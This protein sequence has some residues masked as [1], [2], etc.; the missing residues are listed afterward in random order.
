M[1]KTHHGSIRLPLLLGTLL[2]A[3]VFGAWSAHYLW[4]RLHPAGPIG[5]TTAS[6]RPSVEA[7]PKPKVKAKPKLD[8][9]YLDVVRAAYPEFPATQPLGMPLELSHAAHLILDDPIYL[10]GVPRSEMWITRGD[11]PPIDVVLKEAVDP[12]KDVDVHLVRERIVFVHWTA[13]EPYLVYR[14]TDGSYEVMSIVHGRQ[15]FPVQRRFHWEH[16]FSWNK[17]VVVPAGHGV[18]VFRFDPKI[19]EEYHELA[20]S[21]STTR[22]ASEYPEPRVFQLSVDKP[23]LIAWLPWEDGKIGGTGA[24]RYAEPSDAPDPDL[25]DGTWTDL[26]PQAGWPEKILH[27]VPLRDGTVL[28]MIV[29]SRGAVQIQFNTLDR[30]TVNEDQ[31][32]KL[33]DQLADADQIVR[34]KAYDEL[35][36]YGPGIWP[37][38]EKQLKQDPPPE[39]QVRME[40]LLRQRNTPSLNGMLLLG[41]KELKL[42]ARLA[43]GGTVFFAEAGVSIPNLQDL[44]A[45]PVRIVPAWI[46]IRPGRPIEL[47]PERMTSDLTP[48]Q[49]RLN[50]NESDWLVTHDLRGPRRFVGNSFVSMLRKSEHAYTEFVGMDRRGRWLFRQSIDAPP[51]LVID[52]TLPDPSPRLPVWEVTADEVGWTRDGWAVEKAK[53]TY[54]VREN[55]WQQLDQSETVFSKPQDVPPPVEPG[56][57]E[58]PATNPSVNPSTNPST[59]PPTRPAVAATLPSTD[60]ATSSPTTESS[61]TPILTDRNGNR[62]FGGLTDL[63]IVSRAGKETKWDLPPIANGQGP[64]WLVRTSNGRLFLF[65]QPGRVLRI[66]PTPG[67]SEPYV[68]EKVFTHHVPTVANPTRVWLDPDG[69]IIMAWD[70]HLAV[71][72]PAGYVPPAITQLMNVEESEDEDD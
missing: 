54:A 12:A 41:N 44:D 27:L 51:T 40:R 69:R 10:A 67:G 72:F 7:P 38:L 59:N 30:A 21:G 61:L 16:A 1:A 64:V 24:A 31:I 13:T 65:N 49:S 11:A 26:T 29:D 22:P 32:I 14:K 53:F 33:V 20:S 57:P 60:P 58:F 55:G 19:R 71:F 3:V 45:E 50:V 63:T 62:Y 47:L 36:Q 9:G 17:K 52:P 18:S 37:I 66:K 35:S 34:D 25:A 70:N 68:L 4:K 46:S 8:A 23:G 48:G 43:D 2:L 28:M 56:P 42:A 6:T 39:A 5:S 15:L